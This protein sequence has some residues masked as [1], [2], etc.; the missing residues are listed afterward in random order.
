TFLSVGL[1]LQAIEKGYRAIFITMGELVKALKM[2]TISR[3]SQI[4]LKR[5]REAHLLV[6]DDLMF[7]ALDKKE[8]NLFFHFINDIYEETSIIITSKKGPQQWGELIGDEIIAAAI[9]D[10][11]V[12]KSEIIELT[13]DSYR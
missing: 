2:E 13:G 4:L 11:I 5:L 10:R 7:L 1:C 12:Q 9:L 3:R 8:A 6:I